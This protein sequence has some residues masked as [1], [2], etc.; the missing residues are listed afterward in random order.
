MLSAF[1]KRR[2]HVANRLLRIPGIHC[3]VP[4]GAFYIFANVAEAAQTAGYDDADAWAKALLEQEKVA[5]VPDPL[6]VPLLM[7]AF[8]MPLP[9]INCKKRW[10]GLNNL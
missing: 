5:L 7:S 2:D 10:I 9:W 4:Q 6:S 8:P 1:R 3:D